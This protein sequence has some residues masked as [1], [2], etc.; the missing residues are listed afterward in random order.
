M[1]RDLNKKRDGKDIGEKNAENRHDDACQKAG[2]DFIDLL[3]PGVL[4]SQ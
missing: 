2:D 1:E 3:I 4:I